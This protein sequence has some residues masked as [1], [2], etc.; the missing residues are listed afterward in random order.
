MTVRYV[1]QTAIWLVAMAALLFIPAHT[2]RWPQAWVFLAELGAASFLVGFWLLRHDPDLLAQ[3]MSSPVQRAQPLWDRILMSCFVVL[4]VGWMILIVLGAAPSR[5]SQ[6]PVWAQVLGALGIATSFSI[7]WLVF[8]A[9]SYAAPVVKIQKER[10]QLIV[11]GGPY[12]YVRH[13]MYAGAIAFFLG[14]PLLLGSWLGLALAP[15]LVVLIAVRAVLEE[16]TLSGEFA[17]DYAE[18]RARVR[19]RLIPYLW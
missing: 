19:Y 4:F 3:R 14:V 2:F 16:R 17:A 15:L 10:G 6:M 13:P 1:V 8:R 12:G 5:S 7:S 9:N 18:Y 11:T